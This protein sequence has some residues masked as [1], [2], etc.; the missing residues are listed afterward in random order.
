MKHLK[1]VEDRL[2]GRSPADVAVRLTSRQTA[3]AGAPQSLRPARDAMAS[4]RGRGGAQ[5]SY[6]ADLAADAGRA[7]RGAT[8]LS[9]NAYKVPMFEA[10][11]RAILAAAAS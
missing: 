5:W 4:A 7:A 2:I 11:E 10:A 1:L 8:S 3:S 6:H 9:D